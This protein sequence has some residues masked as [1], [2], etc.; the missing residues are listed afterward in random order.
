[1]L[2]LLQLCI[3]MHR[4][5]TGGYVID[6]TI[7][8]NEAPTSILRSFA[9]LRIPHHNR[10]RSGPRLEPK[11]SVFTAI[12]APRVDARRHDPVGGI[13]DCSLT[14]LQGASGLH[15]IICPFKLFYPGVRDS[16]RF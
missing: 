10:P 13:C 4:H 11:N 14:E 16:F 3:P 9:G 12:Y 8:I 1:M 6:H 7:L 2:C 5:S 15:V